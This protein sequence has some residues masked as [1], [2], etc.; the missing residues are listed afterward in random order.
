MNFFYSHSGSF[1]R[2]PTSLFG[3]PTSWRLSIPGSFR[4]SFTSFHPA[5]MPP[6]LHLSSY[7]SLSGSMLIAL[8]ERF[9][10]PADDDGAELEFY[11]AGYGLHLL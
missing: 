11:A 4:R 8:R 2:F 9:F 6:A 1:Y 5:S 7:A 10:T 3:S